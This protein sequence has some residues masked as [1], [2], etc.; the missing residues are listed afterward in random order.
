MAAAA[1]LFMV[2]SAMAMDS[3]AAESLVKASM[4]L[5]CHDI[6]HKKIGPAYHDVAQKY[7]GQ[8]GALE[9]I[10]RHITTAPIVKMPS[11]MMA[12]HMVIKSS[13]PARVKNVAEWILSR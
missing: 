12:K 1:A 2:N 13:D 6:A 10:A 3:A 7:K 4:C 11:G 5:I 9:K 8:T